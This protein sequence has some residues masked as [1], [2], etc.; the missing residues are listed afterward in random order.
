MATRIQ[1]EQKAVD[2]LKKLEKQE[3]NR[4]LDKMKIISQNVRRHLEGL[5]NIDENKI[6]IGNYRLFV[7]YKLPEDLLIVYTIKHRKNAYK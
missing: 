4:I 6:R 2:F 7:E 5:N 3:T 1:Y